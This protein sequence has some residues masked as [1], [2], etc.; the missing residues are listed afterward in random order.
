MKASVRTLRLLR[1]APS[2]CRSKV[3]K[4]QEETLLAPLLGTKVTIMPL[5]ANSLPIKTTI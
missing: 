1:E 5:A 2:R 3:G 4:V